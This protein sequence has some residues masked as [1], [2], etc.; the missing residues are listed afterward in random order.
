LTDSSKAARNANGT[1]TDAL[2]SQSPET[3]SGSDSVDLERL[4]DEIYAILERRLTIER[5]S[6]GQ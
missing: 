2:D 4:A 5:E 3:N 1:S 6:L